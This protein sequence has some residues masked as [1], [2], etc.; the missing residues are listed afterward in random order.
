MKSPYRW[1][2]PK[3][4][5]ILRPLVVLFL[6]ATLI[7][8]TPQMTNIISGSSDGLQPNF[9]QTIALVSKAESAG[10]TSD[11]VAELL[12]LLNRA[13]KLDEEAFK[14]TRPDDT[15]RK[16]ELLSEVDG[17]LGNVQAKANQLEV[18]ASQR[19]F[20]NKIVAYLSG[21]IAAFVATVAYSYATSFW[22]RYR[23]KRTFQMRIIPK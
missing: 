6:S 20:T 8:L 22:R 9:N 13:L 5:C 11:E 7:F 2:S 1:R 19:T 18:V 17:I 16:A 12:M 23:I 14:L 15:Q 3:M 10:A 4:T 21:G